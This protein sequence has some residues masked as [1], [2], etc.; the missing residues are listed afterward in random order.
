MVGDLLHNIMNIKCKVIFNAKIV[1]LFLIHV[2]I[3]FIENHIEK[4]E[5]V[6]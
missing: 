2:A 5:Q 4:Y 6:L 3:Y 1:N